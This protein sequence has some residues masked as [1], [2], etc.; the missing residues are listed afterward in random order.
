MSVSSETSEAMYLPL[1]QTNGFI[2]I[3]AA[4]GR[5]IRGHYCYKTN[6]YAGLLR[7]EVGVFLI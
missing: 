4:N 1:L 6:S 3:F 5:K 2:K 7:A